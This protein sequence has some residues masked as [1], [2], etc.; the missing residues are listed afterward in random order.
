MAYLKAAAEPSLKSVGTRMRLMVMVV[1]GQ[2]CEPCTNMDFDGHT[3]TMAGP[4]QNDR[5]SRQGAKFSG[6]LR[7]IHEP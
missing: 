7:K 4:K 2:S 1:P 6:G 3:T 5:L